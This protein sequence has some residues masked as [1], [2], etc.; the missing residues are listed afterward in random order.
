LIHNGAI[1]DLLLARREVN[2]E[3]EENP[4]DWNT[5][6]SF[7]IADYRRLLHEAIARTALA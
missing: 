7:G 2:R 6:A 4:F 3:D 5:L 1:V